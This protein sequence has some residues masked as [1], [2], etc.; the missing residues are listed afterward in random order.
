MSEHRWKRHLGWL[1]N[2]LTLANL[3]LGFLALVF[4]QAGY[5]LLTLLALMLAAGLADVLDGAAARWL[6]HTSLLGAQLDSLADL[7]T[8]GV[9]PAAVG[10]GVVSHAVAD[11]AGFWLYLPPLVAY[12]MAVAIRLAR[13][14]IHAQTTSPFFSGLPSPAAGLLLMGSLSVSSL[15]CLTCDDYLPEA[16][17]IYISVLSL[18]LGYLMISRRPFLS[19]KAH[20][21][22]TWIFWVGICLSGVIAILAA[23]VFWSGIV[24]VAYLGLS[25]L[26]H[27]RSRSQVSSPALPLGR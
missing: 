12:P 18:T 19:V 7:V 14:N 8:F 22:T 15:R 24:L 27:R 3:G 11:Q 13:F 5:S 23:A 6:G 4:Y 21:R 2:A 20:L 10:F 9:V 1:P 26:A 16:S 25:W 17:A